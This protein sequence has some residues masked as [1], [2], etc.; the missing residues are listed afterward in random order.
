MGPQEAVGFEIQTLGDRVM[1][2]RKDD[3]TNGHIGVNM[4]P[5]N[6]AVHGEADGF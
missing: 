6:H 4:K 5:E 2:R 3:V 1:A